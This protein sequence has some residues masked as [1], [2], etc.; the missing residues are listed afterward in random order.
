MISSETTEIERWMWDSGTFRFC[1]ITSCLT[2]CHICFMHI[3]AFSY[4]LLQILVCWPATLCSFLEGYCRF[5]GIFCYSGTYIPKM[6]TAYW[7]EISVF[8]CKATIWTVTAMKIS[9]LIYVWYLVK[10]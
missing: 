9:R 3:E 8:A 7:A 2:I 6:G 5:R 1:C 10:Y 4:I